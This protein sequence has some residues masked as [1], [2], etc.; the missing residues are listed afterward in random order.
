MV[1]RQTSKGVTSP[2]RIRAVGCTATCQALVA[3]ACTKL[4]LRLAE[5][6]HNFKDLPGRKGIVLCFAPLECG[7]TKSVTR[8]SRQTLPLYSLQT[9]LLRTTH[10]T[11][12]CSQQ[13]LNQSVHPLVPRCPAA[14]A[15]KC[16]LDSVPPLLDFL[17]T[18]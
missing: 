5:V 7:F 11:Q 1:R 12:Q 14:T 3:C 9:R 10:S 15:R 8:P 16:R 2:T 13:R 6:K 4:R 17:A 18:L